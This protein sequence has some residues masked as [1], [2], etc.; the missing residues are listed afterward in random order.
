MEVHCEHCGEQFLANCPCCG[1]ATPVAG[2]TEALFV[3]GVLLAVG[4]TWLIGAML[5]TTAGVVTGVCAA[6]GLTIAI[7][8]S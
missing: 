7:L 2:R 4:S 5:G 8:S 3:L 1:Q 6:V